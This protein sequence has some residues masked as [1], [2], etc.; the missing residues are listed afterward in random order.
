[1]DNLFFESREGG[2]VPRGFNRCGRGG[3]CLEGG[4]RLDA[5]FNFTRGGELEEEEF[6]LG[7]IGP[8]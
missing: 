2:D 5:F 6:D 4:T 8:A 7:L 3:G 1:M